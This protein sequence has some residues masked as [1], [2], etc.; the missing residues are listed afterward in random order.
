[1]LSSVGLPRDGQLDVTSDLSVAVASS[2]VD[3][4]LGAT[5]VAVLLS[6]SVFG[7]LAV[8]APRDGR[9]V[10]CPAL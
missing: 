2:A 8:K 3:F 1:M 5:F 6:V 9:D 7:V 10:I 4:A